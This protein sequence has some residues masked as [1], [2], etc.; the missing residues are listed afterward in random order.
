MEAFDIKSTHNVSVFIVQAYM[1]FCLVMVLYR[2]PDIQHFLYTDSRTHNQTLVLVARKWLSRASGLSKLSLSTTRLLW[3]DRHT[4][5]YGR[6]WY[7]I[8]TEFYRKLF[9]FNPFTLRDPLESIVCY[10]HT[11]QNNFGIKQKFTK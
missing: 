11:F 5:V 7:L 3:E 2:V 4:R 8:V 1:C 10:S 9:L 6:C